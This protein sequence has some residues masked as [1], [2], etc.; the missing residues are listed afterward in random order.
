MKTLEEFKD[1]ILKIINNGGIIGKVFIKEE[2]D[3]YKPSIKL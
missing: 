2:P 1:E 3:N